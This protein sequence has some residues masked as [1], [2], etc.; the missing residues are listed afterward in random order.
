MKS[1][2]WLSIFFILLFLGIGSFMLLNYIVD[3]FGYFTLTKGEDLFDSEDYSRAIK[4]DYF[5]ENSDQFDAVVLGG[6]KG[7]VLSTE[8][9]S[10]YTGK[11]YY[12]FYSNQGNFSDYLTYGK[13]LIDNTDISEITLHLSSFEV[14]AYEKESTGAAVYQVPAIVSGNKWDQI[15]EVLNFLMTDIK[16]A[17]ET[18]SQ[19][20]DV[21][22][23]T[24]DDVATGTRHWAKSIRLF[25]KDPDAFIAKYVTQSST[26]YLKS[27]FNQKAN[28]LTAFD[29]NIAA[30][31]ELKAYCDKHNVTLKVVIGASFLTERYLYECSRYYDYLREI[32]EITDVW[33]FSDYNDININPYNFYNFKHYDTAVADLMVNTMY[34]GEAREGFGIYLTKDNIEAYLEKRIADYEQL[35]EEFETTGA[36]QLEGMDDDSYIR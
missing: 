22:D 27:L 14:K 34:G 21:T 18:A 20:K 5:T 8:L 32:V 1:K 4:A 25:E 13:Y 29:D 3:P 12:N 23:G 17:L 33:D 28:S 10:S 2:H 15:K 11:R 16:T 9:L 31:R 30:L 24:Y 6:S 19:K 36:I 35:K 7:G 26:K